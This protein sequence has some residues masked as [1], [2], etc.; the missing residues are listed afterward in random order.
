MAYLVSSLSWSSNSWRSLLN[1]SIE[2]S[3]CSIDSRMYSSVAV[4]IYFSFVCGYLD[5]LSILENRPCV[6][7]M[8][9]LFTAELLRPNLYGT[10][11]I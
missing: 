3:H 11:G 5:I 7:A 6:K 4:L 1:A 2:N 8:F 9:L 10:I